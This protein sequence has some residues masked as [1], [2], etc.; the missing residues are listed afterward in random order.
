M[1]NLMYL[2]RTNLKRAVRKG[3]SLMEVLIGIA[4]F[5]IGM[6]ALAALQ[7]NLTRSA[8]DANVRMVATNFGEAL[9]EARK[10]FARIATDPGGIFPAY[11]D[12][13]NETITIT[14]AGIV[15]TI[16]STVTDYY[17][18]LSGDN[19]STTAPDGVSVSDF[20]YIQVT[21]SWVAPDFRT[22]E[23]AE[24]TGASLGTGSISITDSISSLSSLASSRVVTA[25][26]VELDA[27][28]VD[29]S[30]GQRPDIVSLSLGDNKFKES[31]LPEPD[32]IREGELVETRFDV[33]TYSQTNTGALFLRREEFIA[34]ACEC[35]LKAPPGDDES[36]G[37]RPT[38]WAGDE[39]AEGHFV[40]KPY[41]ISAVQ[42]QSPFCDL[43]C[44]DHHDGGS[45]VDDHTDT[46]VNQFYPFRDTGDY[47]GTGSFSGDH[48]HYNRVRQ[49][50]NPVT[51]VLANAV[52]DVYVEA[53]RLVRKDGFFKV[54]QDFRQEDLNVFPEDFLDNQSEVDTYSLYVTGA[55]DAYENA[56]YPD[57]ES[58]PPCI[59]GPL[60]CVA[61]PTYGAAYP[62][63][64]AA[65]ELP[66][67][68][69]LSSIAVLEQQLRSRGVYIDYLSFDI[70]TVIDCL[71][72][73]GNVDTCHTGDVILDRTESANVLEII[74]FFDV[75]MTFL[76]RWNETP[77]NTPVDTTNEGLEDNNTHSRGVASRDAFGASTVESKGNQNNIGFTDTAAIDFNFLADLSTATL[78]VQSLDDSGGGGGIPFDPNDPLASGE[79]TETVRGLR[80]TDI[81]VE[82]QL[83]ALC[84]RTPSGF[85]C[86]IPPA[87][88][89]AGR[90]K[91]F[92]YGK[93]GVDRF[94]CL[95]GL[96]LPLQS[97]VSNGQNAHAIFYLGGDPSPNGP[98]Y[99]INIQSTPCLLS[100]L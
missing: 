74:P 55:A 66:S 98:G 92:A 39:Y 21:V 79:L 87:A 29:Y 83:G 89:S 27:L 48:K 3:F 67:W 18:I 96:L 31:L 41:G 25:T 20:K 11:A 36:A 8:A 95:T 19:F 61:E 85:E 42:L 45:S 72:G 93:E 81:E 30:P 4:I 15:Y 24:T 94:A 60:P 54:A 49:G 63:A 68:S 78:I 53:C 88:R 23:G 65:G 50:N 38:I 46:A 69:E 10:G 52:D 7:G 64:L 70:R 51:L 82:G 26:D 9:I 97:E 6:M 13:G 34:I 90:V 71:R 43:C 58:S 22:T 40:D 28:P 5:A 12:I 77:T 1:R 100:L 17:Y 37:R 59:G 16:A 80:A 2:K 86:S 99:N 57:Y 76:N 32:V 47:F 75:Q 73:G 91:I 62:T 35:A 56:A 14:Q 84:E 44:R 33:I